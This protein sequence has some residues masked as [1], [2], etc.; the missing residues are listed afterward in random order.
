MKIKH[1]LFL[2]H[3]S[4]LLLTAFCILLMAILATNV[5]PTY[6]ATFSSKNPDAWLNTD[7]MP[8]LS[9]PP[10]STNEATPMNIPLINAQQGCARGKPAPIAAPIT[11]GISAAGSH[12]P[13]KEVALTFD[14]GPYGANTVQILNVLEAYHAPAT[15]FS[16]G[17]FIQQFPS[18][19][20]RELN[21]GFAV[22]IHTWNHPH[23]TTLTSNQINWQLHASIDAFHAAAGA[24]ACIWLWR[25]PYGEYNSPVLS[26]ASAHG[27]STIIWND[28]GEDSRQTSSKQHII[29][30]V[31]Q[32]L[33]PSSI[34]L[35]HDGPRNFPELTGLALP[36]IIQGLRARGYQLVTV[37]QLLADEE[38]PGV[39][40]GHPQKIADKV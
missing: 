18:L 23:M 28:F 40:T 20:R 39:A 35:L 7:P 32:E 31:F 36:A 22:G 10:T 26:A 8:Q 29:N 6:A 2:R 15:F 3:R 33:T 17:Q 19:I 25:P 4:L 16:E 21:D 5:L 24:Q 11:D 14:D 9:D 30:T 37:P 1:D 38:S 12:Q 13:L 34:I 27:L